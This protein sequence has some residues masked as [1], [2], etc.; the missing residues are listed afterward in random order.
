MDMLN[1]GCPERASRSNSHSSTSN[2]SPLSSDA[3]RLWA[4]VSSPPWLGMAMSSR[5]NSS[6]PS[7]SKAPRAL[8]STSFM[9][10]I[11]SVLHTRYGLRRRGKIKAPIRHL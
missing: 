10:G 2:P 9:A 7:T 11:Y 4:A 8:L 6:I 5:R 3:T 1:E